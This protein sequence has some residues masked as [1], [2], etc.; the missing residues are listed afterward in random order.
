MAHVQKR[1]L[2][3]TTSY[4]ARIRLPD[5]RER[6][7]SFAR[8]VD[9][10]RWLHSSQAELDR[11]NILDPAAGRMTFG[12]YAERWRGMQVHRH[13]TASVTKSRLERR[14]LPEFGHRRLASVLPSEVQAWVKKLSGS[15]APSTVEATYRLLATIFRSAVADRLIPSSPCIPI[16]L[17]KANSGPVVPLSVDQVRAVRSLMPERAQ[18]MVSVAA[19]VGLRRGEVLGLTVDRIDFLRRTMTVDRQ[20]VQAPGEGMQFGPPKTTASIRT[21]PV[22]ED[23]IKE[24]ARHLEIHPADHPRGLVFTNTQ[25]RAWSRSRFSDIWRTA[26]DDAKLPTGTRFHDLRHHTASLLIAAGCSVKV[27]QH[28]LGHASATETLDTYSH[29]WPNDDERVRNAI[30]DAYRQAIM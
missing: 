23:V 19:G 2:K 28:Q 7:R 21:V 11:G 1:T 22:P 25:Q 5:G 12:T 3:G 26:A 4:R 8:K 17:P 15:Y 24:L 6:T 13:S 14:I 30:D 29:L 16:Q 10:E 9:A 20:L 18:V 27:V